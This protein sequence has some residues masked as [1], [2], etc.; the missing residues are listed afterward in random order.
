MGNTVI[1]GLGKVFF[2]HMLRLDFEDHPNK[3]K[4]NLKAP[5]PLSQGF[6]DTSKR[7]TISCKMWTFYSVRG[8]GMVFHSAAVISFD[9]SPYADRTQGVYLHYMIITTLQRGRCFLPLKYSLKF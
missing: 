5:F 9:Y 2:L 6:Q 4:G 3:K 1:V 8:M 7:I